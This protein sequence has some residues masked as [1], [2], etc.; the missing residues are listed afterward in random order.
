MEQTTKKQKMSVYFPPDLL[1]KVRES[2]KKHHRSFNQE[3]LFILDKEVNKEAY[4]RQ[5]RDESERAVLYTGL[6]MLTELVEAPT[7]EYRNVAKKY[8]AHISREQAQELLK[9]L[10]ER[11]HFPEQEKE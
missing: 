7:G 4:E 11:F 5:L 10:Q 6:K 1:E 2:A 9:G 8:N 3:V